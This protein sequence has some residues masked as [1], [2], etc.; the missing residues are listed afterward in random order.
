M[1]RV[2]ECGVLRITLGPGCPPPQADCVGLLSCPGQRYGGLAF[3]GRARCALVV[4]CT[5]AHDRGWPAAAGWAY[6]P[7]RSVCLAPDVPGALPRGRISG[8]P[9][10]SAQS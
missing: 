10:T 1:A 5:M 3:S 7:A 9:V 6:R 8:R 2:K 4:F